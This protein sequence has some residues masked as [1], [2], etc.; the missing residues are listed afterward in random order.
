MVDI[1]AIGS[2]EARARLTG[3]RVTRRKVQTYAISGG[4][5]A[6]VGI[7]VNAQTA[8]GAPTAGDQFILSSVAAVVIGGASIFGGRG[9]IAS[10]IMGAIAFLMIPDLVYA[11]NLTSFWSTFFQGFLL[12]AAVSVTSIT[13]RIS[14]RKAR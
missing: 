11:L 9:S 13:L 1:L 14:A 10:S 8:S 6:L 3:V 12:I 4:L 5:A 2:D 7:W